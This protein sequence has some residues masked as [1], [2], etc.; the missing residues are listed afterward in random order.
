MQNNLCIHGHFY[1]PPREDP[2]L[3]EVLP[4]GS[5]APGLHWNERIGRESYGPLAWA[6]RT[7]GE[8]RI[9]EII[10][11][12]A[13]ISFNLGPTLLSWMERCDPATYARVLEGDAQ[14]VE[15]WGHGNAMA[16][17]YHHIIMPLATP[18]DKEVETAWGLDDFQA[19]F[20]RP[21]E[22]MWLSEAAVDTASLD[23]LARA[24]VRF[25][26]LAPRQA[27]AVAPLDQEAWTPVAEYELDVTRPY[28]LDLPSGRSMAVFFYHGPL[29][30]SVAFERLLENGEIFWQRISSFFR[31]R[32]NA[33]T[34]LLSLATD[35]ET[36]GH[37][38]AFGEMA[39]AYVLAQTFFGRDDITLTNFAAFL[40][41]RPPTM[42]V[43]LHEPSSWSCVHGVE[44]WRRDCGCTTGGHPGWNQR[45]RA[46]LREGL[47]RL[48][49]GF[50]RHFFAR[51]KDL[52]LDPKQALLAHGKVL[53]G[54]QDQEAFAQA[55]FRTKLDAAQ[56]Q[57]AW[58][59]LGMQQW[60]L[61]SLA[62]CAW[63]FDEISRIEP[64]NGLTYALRAMELCQA[65]GGPSLEEQEAG[66]CAV[67]ERARSN[68]PDKG[69]GRDLYVNEV[70][71]R[72]E[73]PDSMGA[74][75]LLRLWAQGHVPTREK[76]DVSW[77]GVRAS[78]WSDDMPKGGVREGRLALFW[79]HEHEED[80]YHWRWE[81]GQ[82]NDPLKDIFVVAPEAGR[83][84]KVKQSRAFRPEA[85][86]WNKL[87]ALA[88]ELVE[89]ATQQEWEEQCA[90]LRAVPR[91]FLPWQEAQT[92]QNRREYWV[93][94]W[95]VLAWLYVQGFDLPQGGAVGAPQK[96]NGLMAAS[97]GCLTGF[98]AET[99]KEH[100]DG[101]LLGRRVVEH[102]LQL[103]DSTPPLWK[104]AL[105][106]V[107][108]CR[109][110]ELRVDW[111]AAQNRVWAL[112]LDAPE[113]RSLAEGLGFRG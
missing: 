66:L 70:R 13:W 110:I 42:R 34:G 9:I 107:E 97:A 104:S 99:G 76:R 92:T 35:G 56:R 16:Q 43:R 61:A 28:R 22:G 57:A 36:Y 75:A 98:L 100:P 63:F 8:G 62:S 80:R 10:N 29:S 38:F 41:K 78:V 45:W 2:W 1:Q 49:L 102:V 90:R 33:E 7:D 95:P 46:P 4:E 31:E 64:L 71:P 106:V 87:Q 20:G 105:K 79:R 112:G 81:R 59:L 60:G 84:A 108:R 18:L 83:A 68:Y 77:H 109:D 51:G 26:I 55:Q 91:L 103:L 94:L 58:R 96:P 111:W 93:R 67:L 89:N 52:F 39:L 86:P 30:Q 53:A 19:R 25:V 73:T 88:L 101:A 48:K 27:K 3:R 12:Y 21:A 82:G 24:G 113:A 11:T 37:H 65:T 15:R 32:S 6:R 85:L 54:S 17:I 40:A 14:S 50:D 44:R 47:D 5:A 69:T 23:V 72:L 74:Q